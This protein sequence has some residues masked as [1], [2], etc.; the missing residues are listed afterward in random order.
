M[1]N[2]SIRTKI[3]ASVVVVNLLGAMAIMVY[4]HQSY[5]GALDTTTAAIATEGVA[6]WDQIK[7]TTTALD[8]V[9]TPAEAS[10][11]LDGMK[12]IT[13]SDY[14]LLIDKATTT[15]EA[16][17][18]S[19]E[20]LGL[21][22]DWDERDTYALLVATDDGIAERMQFSLTPDSIPEAGK[23]I[24]VENGA[25]SQL[26]HES[27]TGEGDYWT[28]RWSTDSTSRGHA[29]FPIVNGSGA[30]VGAVYS[31]ENISQQANAARASMNQTLLAVALTLIAATLVIGALIDTLVLKRLARMTASIQDISLRIAGGDFDA[32]YEPDGSTDEIGSFERFFSDLI[33]LMSATLKSLLKE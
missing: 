29:I 13:G 23:I 24:G 18:A 8:P 30:V 27:V 2:L 15:P 22:N 6:A 25:C 7:G 17:I 31:I 26:C 5:S 10:R 19:R 3:L 33:T 11:I 12:A 21:A 32:H 28:V 16:F 9:A 20:K 1:K 14:G 4:L